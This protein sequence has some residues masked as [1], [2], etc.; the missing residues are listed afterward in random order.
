VLLTADNEYAR[1]IMSS[2]VTRRDNWSAYY[3]VF[4]PRNTFILPTSYF[5]HKQ[6]YRLQMK[7]TQATLAKGGFVSTMARAIVYGPM[8]YGGV[9][10]VPLAVKNFTRKGWGCR[11][12]C[13]PSV[14]ER[15]RNISTSGASNFFLSF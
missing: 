3:A 15:R 5:T 13:F 6:L 1:I 7:T 10:P 4:L 9:T 11:A 2:P 12:G 8:I 14:L